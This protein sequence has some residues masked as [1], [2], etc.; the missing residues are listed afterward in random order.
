MQAI[1]RYPFVLAAIMLC[2]WASAS[3]GR[4][5]PEFTQLVEEYGP[6]VVN[7]GTTST[8]PKG[9]GGMPK[10]FKIPDIP[11]DS[12]LHDFLKK[13]FE[14]Q[15][16]FGS[17]IPAESLGSGF[18]ISRD[19]YVITNN[20]VVKNADEI[21]VRLSDRREF[22]AK[23]I[24]TDERSD[25]AVL[26]IDA[27]DL[28]TVKVGSS[29][30]LKVGEWV[31]AIGSPFGFDHSA[32][33]GI[34]SAKGRS[35]P[36][37]NYT[38]FI[39]TDVAINPGNSGGPLFNLDGEVVGVNSQI[40]SRTGGFMGLSFAIPIEVVMNVYEQLRDKGAVSRGWLGVI[41]Q[42]VTQDLAESFR[43]D[44]PHGA[45]VSKVV[46]DGPAAKAG[47]QA[48][49]VVLEFAG[50]PI[51]TSSDLPPLV[52]STRIG[53]TVPL[54]V[55]R[56]GRVESLQVAVAELPK[57]D[58][59]APMLGGREG[60]PNGSTD[61]QLKITVSDLTKQQRDELE[62]EDRG[63]MVSE[64]EDGPAYKAGIREGDVIM[65]VDNQKV[66]SARQ[67]KEIVDRLPGGKS[68]PILIQ[69]RGGPV[70]L[71]LKVPGDDKG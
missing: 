57:E 71:A 15:E 53:E 4:S 27:Q 59:L 37:E 49:D 50:R 42:D 33:A 21:M 60:T 32:T 48:G 39:Q 55:M 3:S 46:P 47:I 11:E 54:K 26:K 24:G 6:A 29:A 70:F 61:S 40:F 63:V 43:M 14:G 66:E 8:G 1:K 19:G 41:I 67:F 10:D 23:L 22:K 18:I 17:D 64:V 44:K 35:L 5:L 34:V 69:R 7:I 51:D 30:D 65:M 20:H 58:E 52:G 16:G 13:F 31:L 9:G 36:N 68:V 25:L 2:A 38:P 45:L 12:P 56:N 62:V 28:P